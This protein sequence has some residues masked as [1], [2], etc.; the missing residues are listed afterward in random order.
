MT[1]QAASPPAG[2]SSS[3]LARL[4]RLR[5]R[6]VATVR[7]LGADVEAMGLARL[8]TNVDDEHDPEGVTIAFERSLTDA[9]LQRSVRAIGEIDA[10]IER[11][12]SGT[13]GDCERCGAPIGEA[14]LDAR[15][16]TRFCIR[17]A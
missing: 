14:R 8:D 16:Y 10:A 7:G 3:W 5:E 6:E 11:A 15:P 2:P 9:L 1:D 4:E 17:H 12:A 13:F